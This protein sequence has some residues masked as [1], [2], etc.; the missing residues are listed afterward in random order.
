[1][2]HLTEKSAKAIQ[3]I[4][5]TWIVLYEIFAICRSSGMMSKSLE[6]LI[7]DTSSQGDD[8][9]MNSKLNRLSNTLDAVNR[10]LEMKKL[11]IGAGGYR[12]R[13]VNK[14]RSP[15]ITRE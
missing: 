5:Y 11:T 12:S 10:V 14:H 6:Q 13:L 2:Q 8:E 4:R 3:L 7:G 1:M 9:S 15:S